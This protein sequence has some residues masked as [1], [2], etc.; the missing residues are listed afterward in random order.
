MDNWLSLLEGKEVVAAILGALI[1][2]FL[3]GATTYWATARLSKAQQRN[4]ERSLC[5]VILFEVYEHQASLA[6]DLD[7]ILPVWLGRHCD[8]KKADPYIRKITAFMP[9]LSDRVFAQFFATVV[10]TPIGVSLMSYYSRVKRHNEIAS[11]YREGISG[12]MV[13]KYV[14]L[15]S[16]LIEGGVSIIQRIRAMKGISPWLTSEEHELIFADFDSQQERFLYMAALSRVS[17]SA[18]RNLEESK[19]V[20][21]GFPDVIQKD[22][23]QRWRDWYYA[24]NKLHF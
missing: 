1:G 13:G 20:T 5:S 18:L 6:L 22:S 14:M 4:L 11:Q 12:D 3:G 8:N 19:P 23:Q 7:R 9:Q 10:T 21:S 17:R 16:L 24:A 2:A 15:L